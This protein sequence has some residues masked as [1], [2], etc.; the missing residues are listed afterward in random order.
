MWED[1]MSTAS[2]I[3]LLAL[4]AFIIDRAI[5][6]VM[7]FASWR[8]AAADAA[9]RLERNR[10]VLYGS[11]SGVLAIALMLIFRDMRVGPTL[12][13]KPAFEPFLTWLVLMAGAE[14]VSS[15][16]GNSAPKPARAEERAMLQVTGTIQL[17]AES[18]EKLRE[19]A[20]K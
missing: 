10:K 15:F 1:P 13:G 19:A 5:A 6:T 12:F 14:R 8:K 3:A 2:L 4:C 18:A 17:D 16:V 20:A 9:A 11:L 7:F